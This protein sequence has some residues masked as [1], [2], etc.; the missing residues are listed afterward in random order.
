MNRALIFLLETFLGL[1]AL[2]LLLRF[3]MQAV[4]APARNPLSNFIAALT[5]FA[6]LPARRVIPGLWG[7]D[8]SSLVLAWIVELVLVVTVLSLKGYELSGAV[9]AAAIG[10][11]LLA[12]VSLL[13]L[14]VYIVMFTT[15]AQAILS[16]VSPYSPAMP[17]LHSMTRPF[18]RIFQRR[19]PPIGG[20]DLSPLFVL[21]ICQLLIMWPL[22][23]L[24]ALVA[25]ML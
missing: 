12:V 16:W 20:V 6:V 23:A 17:I 14:F 11:A 25:R 21:V 19:V 3:H 4:R 15:F 7:Y 2:A 10:L 13:R 9:G 5:N 24:E 18:L 8:L 22:V 1:F